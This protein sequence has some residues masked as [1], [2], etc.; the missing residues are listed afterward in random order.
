MCKC[1]VS[2]YKQMAYVMYNYA[3]FL[4]TIVEKDVCGRWL[5]NGFL[6]HEMFNL[7]I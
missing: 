7:L 4:S 5:L 6:S 3:N 2:L 1:E